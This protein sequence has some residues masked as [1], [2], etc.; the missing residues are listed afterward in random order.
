V[1]L[2]LREAKT[3]SS[4]PTGKWDARYVPAFVRRYP[5]VPAKGP[6]GDL[7]V[8]IDEASPCFRRKPRA[9]PC[10]RMASRRRNWIMR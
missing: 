6:Q 1:L 4:T 10:L 5:F 3:C 9:R 7:L 2:G 8:C